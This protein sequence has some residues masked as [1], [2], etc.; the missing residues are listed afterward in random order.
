LARKLSY[1][2]A[3]EELGLSQSALSRSIQS[4]EQETGV[5]LFDRDRGKVR[6]TQHGLAF[7]ERAE[8]LV[9][10]ADDLQS[11]M[12]R[13]ADAE[14][15]EV[16]FGIESL[17]A[18]VLLAD[19]LAESLNQAPMLRTRVQI[20]SIEAL[21]S[22]LI[23]GEIE[24]FISA[25]GRVPATPPARVSRLGVFP[26]SFL[27]RPGH[28]ALTGGKPDG[29]IPVLLA[30]DAGQLEFVPPSLRNLTSGPR[31]IVEDYETLAKLTERSDA[32]L[33]ASR[34]AVL[35]EMAA[36]RIVELPQPGDYQA[37][38]MRIVM[39]SLARRSLSPGALKLKQSFQRHMHRLAQS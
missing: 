26:V 4:L 38:T 18:R 22:R 10:E 13:T 39:Y 3:A 9:A 14:D 29:P 5:R 34:F 12:Q 6:L 35:D 28:P 8:A 30:G 27:V 32:I 15:G 17:P 21:W 20:R 36:G 2:R 11:A 16:C 37:M 33:L 7:M 24:F 31:H 25:E 19:V 23:T 1:T